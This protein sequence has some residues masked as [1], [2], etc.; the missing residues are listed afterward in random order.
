MIKPQF[1]P[2]FILQEAAAAR[3]NG[4]FATAALFVDI[5]GFTAV[6]STLMAQG[7]E[8]AES[9]A[10]S[11]EA[12]FSPLVELVRHYQGFVTGFAGDAFTAIFPANGI[13]PAEASLR[14]VAAA[15]AITD[16]LTAHP[17]YET[18]YGRFPFTAK[19]GV[20]QGAVQWGIVYPPAELES[21]HEI[22]AV[23]YFNGS[24]IE[25]AVE[26]QNQAQRG[27]IILDPTL[28]HLLQEHIQ[29]DPLPHVA[30]LQLRQL[31]T[32][33][34]VPQIDGTAESNGEGAKREII[35]EQFVP[36]AV[37]Q[38]TIRGDFRQVVTVFINVQGI[39]S[40]ADIIDLLTAVF[41]LQVAYGGYLNGLDFGDKGCTLLLFWGTPTSHENDLTRAL[42][43]M[44]AFA[45]ETAVS[46]RA[47]ITYRHMY[48]GM[49]GS[50]QWATFSCYG[51][52]VNLAAR[53]MTAA[54]WGMAWVEETAVRRADT[55]FLFT[56]QDTHTFKGFTQP[57]PTYSLQ[58]RRQNESVTFYQG[59]LIGRQAEQAQIRTFLAPLLTEN[60]SHWA[61]MLVVVGEAGLGKS[62]LLDD[63]LQPLVKNGRLQCTI[64]Q[65]DQIIRQ[66]LNPFR[67]WL[68]HY[69]NQ[70]PN[71]SDA[72]NKQAFTHQLA[73]LKTAVAPP[74]VAE[75]DRLA[76]VLGALI[77][78]HWP[79][80]FY[81]QLD[82]KGRQENSRIALQLLLR[83]ESLRQPLL[84]VLED[85][86]WLD[87]A[88][89]AVLAEVVRNVT[90][91]PLALLATGRMEAEATWPLAQLPHE[92]L[93]LEPLTA[94]AMADIAQQI[95]GAPISAALH[96]LL[97]ERA[98]GNPFFA[99]QIVRYLQD[100]DLLYLG[101][102]VWQLKPTVT[103]A[104][105]PDDLRLLFIARLDRLVT[106]VKEVVQMAAILGREF[107]VNV[108]AHMLHQH[109]A[110][111]VPSQTYLAQGEAARVW[112]MVNDIRYLFRH[113]LLRDAAYE[114]QLVARRREL[115]QLAAQAL[116]SLYAQDL[117][118]RYA[119]IAYHYEMAYQQGMVAVGETAVYYL[120]QAG[121]QAAAAYENQA[122]LDFFNRGLSLTNE[123]TTTIEM[124]LAR[125]A[126]FSLLGQRSEQL[127]DLD[128]LLNLL[129]DHSWPEKMAEVTLRRAQ[130][131][132]DVSDNDTAYQLADKT[133]TLA[134]PLS[135]VELQIKAYLLQ[136]TLLNKQGHN[137]D[138][139]SYKQTALEMAR[140]HHISHLEA[141][142]LVGLSQVVYR[143]SNYQQARIYLEQALNLAR[144]NGNRRQESQIYQA[145][146]NLLLEQPDLNGAAAYLEQTLAVRQLIGDRVGQ[147][148]AFNS[149]GIVADKRGQW[150]EA[151]SYYQ[152]AFAIAAQTS[153]RHIRGKTLGNLGINA[154]QRGDYDSALHY[155]ELALS[156]QQEVGDSFAMSISLLNLGNVA[157]ALG[158]YEAARDYYERV[159]VRQRDSGA[160]WLLGYGLTSWADMLI[161]AE[162]WAEAWTALTEAR[163]IRQEL[164]NLPLLWETEIIMARFY[165][166]QG[167]KQRAY[168]QVGQL[169]PQLSQGHALQD[170]DDPFY[171]YWL[172]YQILA[173]T[174][175]AETAV[176]LNHIYQLLQTQAAQIVDEA[177]RAAFLQ[178]VPW[179]RQITQTWQT[180]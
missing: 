115:H 12:I 69:F 42:S 22:T 159:L 163:E 7:S 152:E 94:A 153:E 127:A 90:D 178:N 134:N 27:Q 55:T 162:R 18:P 125:E 161:A 68:R 172:V 129:A 37:R 154:Y 132:L 71:Q 26:A 176:F 138:A 48:S 53:L 17:T 60:P 155:Y 158:S 84:F 25:T 74:L 131:A 145:L 82:S 148:E 160:K 128:H 98:E 180:Y 116:E 146:G 124:L 104:A 19:M 62:R 95:L 3:V 171:L 63:T 99:E 119:E 112:V 170:T 100:K 8:A 16:Y 108:L 165:G 141:E 70:S 41:K 31:L 59:Q 91:A 157:R 2:D 28:A 86:Q 66:P 109:A 38:R 150:A 139:H 140:A 93:L 15:V 89:Q 113:A 45:Q 151:F 39:D 52:G 114:M 173:E 143:Q 156:L 133:I 54:P 20:G 9:I 117:A 85:V 105:L 179:H 34:P 144:A 6:T 49:A 102:D 166:A 30:Q 21:E 76:S 149:L 81:A 47:G 44:L 126:V 46:W 33:P 56:P 111:P 120:H 147:A 10:D 174:G 32:Q 80:S 79:G 101:D 137:N 122:A 11:M 1:V 40:H 65:V 57:I 24:A 23:Y 36:L 123:P 51:S 130:Y 78:L 169:L 5:S 67:Y 164:G 136:G 61:G 35:Q 135:L 87:E 72:A 106:A 167:D 4:R 75:L 13:S 14:A 103:A 88:S 107:E 97:A 50:R 64:T 58:R 29:T 168:E 92:Q 121:Q 110:R 77:D 83:A 177:A 73:Q 118:A 96:Q 142:A 175:A 43:F